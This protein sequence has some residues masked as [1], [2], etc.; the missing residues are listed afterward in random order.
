LSGEGG[1]ERRREEEREGGR[2]CTCLHASYHVDDE[3]KGEDLLQER[4][5]EAIPWEHSWSREH[6][7][8]Y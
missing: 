4:V 2:M 8:H 3:R 5:P 6:P 7:D 1:K